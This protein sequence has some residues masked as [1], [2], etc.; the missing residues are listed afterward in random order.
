MN[1]GWKDFRIFNSFLNNCA[2][3]NSSITEEIKS[4]KDE[5]RSSFH[6]A[7][8]TPARTSSKTTTTTPS[9]DTVIKESISNSI[10]EELDESKRSVQSHSRSR[11]DDEII[12]KHSTPV[13]DGKKLK[14]SVDGM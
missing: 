5:S 8:R 11:I 10:G 6:K 9:Q 7:S 14:G 1:Q 12:D 2:F 4:A 13:S 3:H